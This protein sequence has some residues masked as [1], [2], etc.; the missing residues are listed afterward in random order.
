VGNKGNFTLMMMMMG[1]KAFCLYYLSNY[2]MPSLKLLNNCHGDDFFTNLFPY[3]CFQVSIILS[4]L[5]YCVMATSTFEAVTN[6]LVSLWGF[7]KIV[8]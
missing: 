8:H 3:W 1:E 6:K 2:E 5:Y 4:V 7:G